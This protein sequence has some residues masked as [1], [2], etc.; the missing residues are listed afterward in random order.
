MGLVLISLLCLKEW[1]AFIT[2]S[3]LRVAFISLSEKNIDYGSKKGELDELRREYIQEKNLPVI[4]MLELE[5]WRLY[6]T[7]TNVQP[8]IRENVP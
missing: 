8:H 7:T 1:V 5:W 2:F 3:M 6:K 4:E